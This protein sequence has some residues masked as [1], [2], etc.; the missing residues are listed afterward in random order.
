VG[1]TFF[2]PK[3][4]EYVTP[5]LALSYN[6]KPDFSGVTLTLRQGVPFHGGW[7]EMTAEDAVWSINDANGAV[8]PTSIHGQAGDFA[9]IFQKAE[10]VDKY[11]MYLPIKM[12]DVRWN[13]M[14]LNHSWQAVSILSKKAYDQKG[15]E[16]SKQNIVATGPFQQV[17]WLRDDHAKLAAVQNHW[18]KPP[19]IKEITFMEV[20]EEQSRLAMMQ[21][22]EADIAELGPAKNIELAKL[23]FKFYGAGAD[24]AQGIFFCGNLWE[25]THAV[26]GEKLSR[27]PLLRDIQWIGNNINPKTSDDPPG[28]DDMEQARL[29]RQALAMSFDRTAINETVLGGLG[30]PSYVMSFNPKDPN[31][32]KEWEFPYDVAQAKELLKKAGYEKGFEIPLFVQTTSPVNYELGDA[33]AGYWMKLGM[34]APVLK[35]NF[36]V[37]RPSLVGR[38]NTIPYLT[39]GDEGMVTIPWDWPRGTT[40][41]SITRGGF[42]GGIESPDVVKWFFEATKEPDMAKRIAINNK[43]AE[44]Y[45]NWA[46]NPAIV[47][48][49][50]SWAANPKSVQSWEQHLSVFYPITSV[51]NIVPAP[52]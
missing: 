37:F 4:Y 30:Y 46:L 39:Q 52:R 22:G 20:P 44:Y 16:W 24:S 47:V 49:P 2:R 48:V 9:P 6:L 18:R 35:Y 32:K 40:L 51:E 33:V 10:V 31:W 14:L 50:K 23:G 25:D 34:T 36:T 21:T 13:S 27:D 17:E 15:E 29:V 43:L 19:A 38:T 11:T 8:T 5:E 26:T 1:E 12:F 3:G 28:I 45:R 41:T 42:G 7:G